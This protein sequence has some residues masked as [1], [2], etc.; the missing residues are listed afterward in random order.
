MLAKAVTEMPTSLGW[1]VGQSP[2]PDRPVDFEAV[3]QAE[4]HILILGSDIQAPVGLEWQ[5]ARRSGRLPVLFEK[6]T[7]HTQA[8]TFF[9]RELSRYAEWQSFKDPDTLR[10]QVLDRLVRHLLRQQVDYALQPEECTRLQDWRKSIRKTPKQT[11][12]ALRGGADASAVI[13][14]TERFTP[15]GGTLL[16]AKEVSQTSR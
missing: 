16:T 8:A 13:L 11:P 6:D 4:V 14:S 3:A 10:V 2:K 7:P 15:S 1:Y 12:D 9:R 5:T